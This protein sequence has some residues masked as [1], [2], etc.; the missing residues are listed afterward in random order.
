MAKPRVILADTDINYIIPLQLKF[1]EE[2]FEKIDLEIITDA[3]YFETL[4]SSPQKVDILVLSEDLY[5]ESLRKHD[6]KNTFL[7]TEKYEE[8]K[9]GDLNITKIFKYTS[10]KEI[11]TVIIGKS[12]VEFGKQI[13]E[14]KKT[15]VVF[16]CAACGGTGKT[17]LA[18]ALSA[19]LTK[20]YKRVLY[21]NAGYLQSFQR[22]LKNET[23][24]SSSDVYTQLMSADAGIYNNIKHIIRKE[25]FDYLPPFRAAIMSLGL[26]FGIYEKIILSAKQS[27]EYDFIV[28]D[29]DAA[30]DENNAR[31]LNLADKVIVVTEQT[32]ASVYATNVF[33]SNLNGVNGDK[34][35]F[36]CNNFRNDKENALI[37]SKIKLKFAISDYVQHIPTFD[38]LNCEELANDKGI[39]KAAFLI[40]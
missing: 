7:M 34:F 19:C 36:I 26:T 25:V 1:V 5:D 21:I 33:V 23:P 2:F 32:F 6:V 35:V 9:T 24:I 18:M 8:E 37:S 29:S 22:L 27:A 16:V 20:N 10:I 15:Q 39:Q 14:K 13:N 38:Q 28:V 3:E 4:F 30:F 17:A 40:L 11:F 12:S 31:L